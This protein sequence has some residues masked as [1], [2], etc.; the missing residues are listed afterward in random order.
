M[1]KLRFSITLIVILVLSNFTVLLAQLAI[2]PPYVSVDGKS[3]VGN[4]Y[5]TNNS[6]QPQEV[7]IS[8]AFGYPGSDAEGNLVMNYTDSI[9]FKLFAID[10]IVRAFPRTFILPANQQRTIRVQI[11]PT[12]GMKDGYYF[13]RA[14]IL[15]K[16]QT[17]EVAKTTVE[18]ISTK[19]SFNFEQVIPAFYKRGK[20]TTGLKIEKIDATQKDSLLVI[21][22]QLDR[23]GDAPF[24]GTMHAKLMDA[25]GKVVA[26]TQTSAT[27]YFKVLRRIDLAIARVAPGTYKLEVSFET[28]RSDMAASDLVQ[29]QPVKETVDVVIK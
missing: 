25:K 3:G 17:T 29:A 26:N 22:T 4:I 6:A 28:K 8:F 16:P 13:T 23:L 27:A 7:E 21:K 18:G 19:I 1:N 11:K 12:P 10:P 5:I 20:V 2:S 9:A 15:A 24:I 14:K